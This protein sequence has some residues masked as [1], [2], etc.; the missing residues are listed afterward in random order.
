M[1]IV[2]LDTEN[3]NFD[4]TSQE[5]VLTHIPSATLPMAC[6]GLILFGDGTD[7]LDGSGG[8]FEATVTLTSPGGSPVEYTIQ[9][10]PQTLAY[11]VAV[12]SGI[13]TV[14]FDVPPNHTVKLKVKSPNAGDT[15]VDVTAYLFDV[16]PFALASAMGALTDAAADGDPTNADT[17]MQY[18]KQLVNVLVGTAGIATFPVEAAPDDAVSIAEVLR[19]VHAD[20]TGLDGDAMP[21]T[22]PTVEQIRA[23]MDAN[24]AMLTAIA[25]YI[26]TEI[27]S[28]ISTL[29]T[30][31]TLAQ[32]TAAF[33]EIK[34]S[35]WAAGTD[36]LEE[37]A[38][39]IAAGAGATPATFFTYTLARLNALASAVAAAA[40]AGEPLEIKRGDT[41]TQAYSLGAYAVADM[42]EVRFA[43]KDSDD[44]TD[45]EAIILISLTG[46]LE[47]FKGAAET[48]PGRGQITLAV[49]SGL[50]VAT[51]TLDENR[52]FSLVKSNQLAFGVQFT[53]AGGVV[54]EFQ[55]GAAKV[56]GDYVRGV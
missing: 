21:G 1:S 7:N 31:P 11:S 51:I 56:T 26:D 16:A 36:T 46:G 18:L 29:G 14:A 22:P 17:A 24:S 34:G 40:T 12:T 19:A 2:Q 28:I 52:T 27:S 54:S 25:G 55:S 32:L 15:D 8:D 20:V 6:R 45:N 41:F 23:E 53:T 49:V 10:D 47:R 44:D 42:A 50:L 43:V 33:T 30:Q 37:I 48:V 5:T 9:P 38:D 35:G 13:F 39:A 3:A 4:L